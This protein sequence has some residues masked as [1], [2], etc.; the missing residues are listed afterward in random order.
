MQIDSQIFLRLAEKAGRLVFVDIEASGLR[1]DYNS[2]LCVS[3]KPYGEKPTTYCVIQPG[4]DKRVVREVKEALEDYDCW[5]GYYSKGFDLPMINTR[6]LK[7]GLEPV[8]KRHH[9]DLYYTLKA[10]LL[11]ARRSQ[12]HLLEWLETPETKMTVSADVWNRV[13]DEETRHAA[14]ATLRR[15]CESDVAGLEALYR[16]TCHIITEIKK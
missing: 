3:L 9:I 1:G 2:I 12:A 6:L 8:E 5:C 10:N 14:L 11:T 15:R 4:N 13:A 16:K 7:W